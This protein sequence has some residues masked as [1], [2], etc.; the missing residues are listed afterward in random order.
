MV[1][2]CSSVSDMSFLN[3]VTPTLGSM[4]QGGIWR[5]STRL[6]IERAQGRASW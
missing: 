1:A 6:L 3:L 4:C 5:D 2:T